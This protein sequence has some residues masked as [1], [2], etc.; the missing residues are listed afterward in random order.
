MLLPVR[1]VASHPATRKQVVIFSED[2]RHYNFLCTNPDHTS[3]VPTIDF[4]YRR[5]THNTVVRRDA[6]VL[7]CRA[8]ADWRKWLVHMLPA[9]V[10]NLDVLAALAFTGLEL[11]TLNKM[12]P[13]RLV[14]NFVIGQ[15][16]KTLRLNEKYV[17]CCCS[18]ARRHHCSSP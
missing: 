11:C 5:L 8:M 4:D 9:A 15:P 16:Q 6:T 7:Q 12:A 17:S 1:C 3:H 14:L 13:L 18:P 2:D 10:P